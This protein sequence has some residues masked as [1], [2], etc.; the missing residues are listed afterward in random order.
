MGE[1]AVEVALDPR[2][3]PQI[4]RLAVPL[5]EPGEDAQDLGRSLRAHRRIGGGE[6]R[7]VEGGVGRR[8]APHI[9]GGQPHLE[10]LRH[11]DARVLQQ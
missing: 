8:P 11:V 4:L 1:I 6:A 3:V 10:I 9:E 7:G 2:Q 5:V